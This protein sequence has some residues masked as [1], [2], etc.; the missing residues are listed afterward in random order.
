MVLLFCQTSI[1][2][3]ERQEQ[4][5]HHPVLWEPCAPRHALN[6]NL[7]SDLKSLKVWCSAVET[8]AR[9]GQNLELLLDL[10]SWLPCS[11]I[12]DTIWLNGIPAAYH[13]SEASLERYLVILTM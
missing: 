9:L 3:I 1:A 13:M 2:T 10:Q 8:L 5:G 12:P 7:T 4:T 11:C 6:T